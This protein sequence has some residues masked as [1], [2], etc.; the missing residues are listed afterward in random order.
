MTHQEIE[1]YYLLTKG[2]EKSF[3]GDHNL[4]AQVYL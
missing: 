2:K 1:G 3:I 4:L